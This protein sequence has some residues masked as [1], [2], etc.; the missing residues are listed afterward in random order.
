MFTEACGSP[1]LPNENMSPR[2]E[3]LY[4]T[5]ENDNTYPRENSY[6][7]TF[8]RVREDR[9][10]MVLAHVFLLGCYNRYRRSQKRVRSRHN[11]YHLAQATRAS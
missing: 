11:A 1:S 8:V 6:L 10:V 2:E 9:R 3:Q 5:W 7:S 4:K